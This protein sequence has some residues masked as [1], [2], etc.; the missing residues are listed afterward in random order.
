IPAAACSKPT[1]STRKIIFMESNLGGMQLHYGR[2]GNHEEFQ[3]AF[4]APEA[5]KYA[6]TARVVTP[7]WKQHLLV[8]ANGAKEPTDIAL[9]FTVGMWDR[10]Q[11]VEVTL[12]K[13]RN[14]L[15]FSREGSVKGVTIKDFTL[16]PMK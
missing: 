1:N 12:V 3:Y 14:V 2:L 7:S 16:K 15:R 10:T 8:A 5:G 13:G 6:L 11:P 9:P 4:D